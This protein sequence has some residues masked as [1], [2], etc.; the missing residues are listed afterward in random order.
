M[1][2]KILILADQK[3][4][5]ISHKRS[6]EKVRQNSEFTLVK[7][8]EQAVD[9]IEK[10]NFSLIVLDTEICDAGKHRTRSKA[11]QE[12]KE[13]S[14]NCPIVSVGTEINHVITALKD[15]ADGFIPIR[16]L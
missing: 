2:K 8:F 15:G 11:I 4:K 9:A 1:P 5:R 7:S 13:K 6:L 16:W 14:R 3:A 10:E 12:L